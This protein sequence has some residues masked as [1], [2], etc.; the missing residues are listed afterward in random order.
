MAVLAFLAR[1]VSVLALGLDFLSRDFPCL[2]PISSSFLCH[3]AKSDDL[4]GLIM[5]K[6]KS[7]EE[8][9]SLWPT[10]RKRVAFSAPK[11]KATK[12]LDCFQ[13]QRK[14][15]TYYDPFIVSNRMY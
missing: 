4:S 7:L 11:D 6:R 12:A 9:A 3:Q 15:S 2:Q 14:Y 5:T 10:S 8:K 1:Q 13:P